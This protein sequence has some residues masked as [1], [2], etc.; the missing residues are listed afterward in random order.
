MFGRRLALVL[1]LA[2][3]CA[4]YEEVT[5]D[6]PDASAADASI[7][8]AS[9]VGVSD[10]GIDATPEPED[11]AVTIASSLSG[12]RVIAM[13]ADALLVGKSG[14]T[15]RIPLS[16][17][18]PP[19][20]VGVDFARALYLDRASDTLLYIRNNE[21]GRQ[22]EGSSVVVRPVPEGQ[23]ILAGGGRMIAVFKN[24]VK[25]W[26]NLPTLGDDITHTPTADGEPHGV[27]T[28]GTNIVWADYKA[29]AVFKASMTGLGVTLFLVPAPTS[30]AIDGTDVLFT[31]GS[32]ILRGPIAGGSP[33][34]IAKDLGHPLSLAVDDAY[35]YWVEA[36][37][38]QYR[39]IEK[40][41]GPIVTFATGAAFSDL[42]YNHLI[43]VDATHVYW[44][45]PAENA[46]YRIKK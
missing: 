21:V 17:L 16:P 3:A 24:S 5:A 7:D 8:D 20:N 43:V 26:A 28:D 38:G 6:A 19:Q 31:S 18:G 12:I 33:S 32:E 30:V 27:A 40:K 10:G 22:R 2:S 35:V 39:R 37:N 25:S 15:Q 29:N 42:T 1:V 34:S 46:V 41:G 36:D 45:Q 9:V 11:A 14:A 23:D 44:A 4:R 13:G